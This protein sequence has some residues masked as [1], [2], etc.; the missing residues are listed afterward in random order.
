MRCTQPLVSGLVVASFGCALEN[1]SPPLQVQ[2]TID[3]V[4]VSCSLMSLG[5]STSWNVGLDAHLDLDV[6]AARTA[7]VWLQEIRL[8]VSGPVDSTLPWSPTNTTVL[9]VLSGT[10]VQTSVLFTISADGCPQTLFDSYIELLATFEDDSTGVQTVASTGPIRPAVINE[11]SCQF[12]G[13][14]STVCGRCFARRCQSVVDNCCYSPQCQGE[15]I[16]A[17]YA[18]TSTGSCAAL[19]SLSDSEDGTVAALRSCVD[20]CGELCTPGASPP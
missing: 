1:L 17:L 5:Q 13:R 10:E 11:T 9:P 4:S 18:C 19:A 7:T 14:T 6:Q 12:P 16:D 20:T 8:Q 2:A 3:A 15:A